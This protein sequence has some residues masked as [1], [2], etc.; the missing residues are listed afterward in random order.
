MSTKASASDTIALID[1]FEKGP[2]RLARAISSLPSALMSKRPTPDEWSVREVLAHLADNAIVAAWR[3]RLVLAQ[4]NPTLQ[5]YD[6][7]A[8]AWPYRHLLPRESLA[9]LRLLRRTTGDLLRRAPPG[10]WERVG[11]HPELGPRTLRQ[12]VEGQLNHLDEHIAQI[13]D[14][15]RR[16]RG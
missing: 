6:G 4:D 9:T 1:A 10:A 11:Q 8:W 5:P 2:R 13:V 15:K 14:I 7:D 16:L 3:I 12:L